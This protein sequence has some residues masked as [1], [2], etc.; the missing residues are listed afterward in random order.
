ME[1]AFGALIVIEKKNHEA[2]TNPRRLPGER[3]Q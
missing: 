3:N 2:Q 1:M